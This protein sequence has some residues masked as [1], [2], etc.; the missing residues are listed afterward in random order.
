MTRHPTR[1]LAATILILFFVSGA[2]GLLY[3]VLWMRQL[4]LVFGSTLFATSAVLSAFM[5]GLAAGA[6]LAGHWFEKRRLRPLLVYGV[7]ELAIGGY[8]VIVPL[9]L[10]ALTPLYRIAW[11]WGGAESFVM[12]SVFKWIGIAVVLLP[13]TML[14][15][16]SLPV[17]SKQV[18]NDSR[19]IGGTVGTLYSMN[20]FGAVAGAFVG[21][22]L[23][24]PAMGAARSLWCTAL[25]NVVVGLVAIALSNRLPS[26]SASPAP[27]DA[28]DAAPPRQPSEVRIALLS[29][30]I[31]GFGAM[32]LE[33]AWTRGLSLV[34]GSSAYAFALMLMAFLSGLASGGITFSLVLR[35][36][37]VEP[38][39]LLA[40]LL[41]SA[42][43]LAFGTAYL[44][45][46]L[47]RMFGE[48]YLRWR[49]GADGMLLVELALGLLVMFPTTFVL[50]GIFPAVLQIRARS[51]AEV[52]GS[53]GTVYASN[54]LGTIVG[55]FAGGF[56]IIPLLGVRD[57]LLLVSVIEVA[58]GIW[59]AWSVARLRTRPRVMLA[60]PM[61]LALALVPILRPGWDDLLMNSGVYY[62]IQ[63]VPKDSGWVDFARKLYKDRKIVFAEE[64][65]TAT[66]VVVSQPRQRNL[67]LAVNGKVDAS[68]RSDL[69]T[70]LL[71]AHVPL[72]LHPHPKDVMIIGLASGITVGAAATHSVESIR[73]VEVERAMV[74]AARLFSEFNGNVLDDPRV[75]ISINDARNELEFSSR[76]YDVIISEPSN[77]FMTVAAN[78]FTEEFFRMASLRVRPG[79]IFLQWVQAYCLPPDDL[80]S[81]VGAFRDAFPQVMIF[82]VDGIDLMLA[83]SRDPIVLDVGQWAERIADPRIGR[84]LAR[85]KVREP[86]DLL[87]LFELGP[88]EVSRLV[89][90]AARNT[91]DNAR[92]EYSA[93]K[94]FAL[95]TTS[96]NREML[97]EYSG[98]PLDH[99]VP[100]PATER[101]RARRL[102]NLA[103][104]WE[105]RDDPLAAEEY[106]RMALDGPLAEESRAMLERLA[107]EDA[108]DPEER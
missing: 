7:L 79:G 56:V 55:A 9:L 104:A 81:I 94:A 90:G 15:G 89:E 21:G 42:G 105:R 86:A 69:D 65:L 38:G 80:R 67:Y 41:G 103:A 50:G 2:T 96:M 97:E 58:L 57:T 19:R 26:T 64:G 37:P 52:P 43:V 106:A 34:M 32:I 91:D 20:T 75:T 27:T 73:V 51:L 88:A 1:L 68:S 39:A 29:F 28:S 13:P 62:Y 84:D 40:A 107:R 92:V 108:G 12:M 18:A 74:K 16:A 49:P 66:V 85:V 71:L 54:T 25:V 23:A 10:R 77:P 31:S 70:Q 17:L 44:L 83:G 63:D 4:I 45:Q 78:L 53:V 24:I 30:G 95:S 22:F 35:R 60:A 99:V 6:Y 93:P 72:M 11:D 101:E 98:E 47:P 102:L 33:V 82:Q 46:T 76:D 8:A 61:A 14:M 100:P 5:G 59:V 36:R 87:P 3:E 48:A